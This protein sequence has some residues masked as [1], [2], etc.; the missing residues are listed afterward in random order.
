M[1]WTESKYNSLFSPV[2]QQ[3]FPCSQNHRHHQ[4]VT[5]HNQ[6]R[7]VENG[8]LWRMTKSG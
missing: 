2:E 1:F 7:R 4:I 3:H 8:L 5:L 6:N